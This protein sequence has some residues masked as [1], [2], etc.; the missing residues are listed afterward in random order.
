MFNHTLNKCGIRLIS[1]T[2]NLDGSLEFV[3]LESVLE[4]LAQYYLLNLFIEIMKGLIENTLNLCDF[5]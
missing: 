3:M 4:R 5:I 2:G 1:I